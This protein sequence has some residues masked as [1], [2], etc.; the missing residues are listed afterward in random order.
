MGMLRLQCGF[1]SE[2]GVKY[3]LNIYDREYDDEVINFEIAAESVVVKHE[4]DPDDPFKRIVPSNLTFNMLLNCD[5]YTTEQ[6]EAIALFY[7]DVSESYEGR[8]FV[9]IR[10]LPFS[11]IDV[12]RGKII[13]DVGDVTMN[14]WRELRI[15][16]I[17][18]L[19]DLKNI[20]YR[21][22]EYSDLTAADAIKTYSFHDHFLAILKKNDVV[23]FFFEDL[24]T[25]LT[26][27]VMSTAFNWTSILSGIG[28]ITRQVR[29]RNHY[30]EQISSTY[31]KY[32]TCYNVLQDMLN[33]FNARI[34]FSTSVYQIE[35]L[36]YQNISPIYR[37][38]TRY[39]GTDNT[40]TR[41]K[42][43]TTIESSV[44]TKVLADPTIKLLPAFKAI[45]LKQTKEFMNYMNGMAIS[46]NGNNGP[47]NFGPVI[48]TGNKLLFQWKVEIFLGTAWSTI[49]W[50]PVTTIEWELSFKCRIGDNYLAVDPVSFPNGKMT[51]SPGVLY[52]VSIGQ[53]PTLQ[54]SVTEE[55]VTLQWSRVITSANST[56]FNNQVSVFRQFIKNIDLIIESFEI[57]DEGDLEIEFMDFVTRRNGS[58]VAGTPPGSIQITK[59][60]RIIVASGYNDLLEPPDDFISYQVNDIRNTLIYKTELKY[61]D[62]EKNELAQLFIGLDEATQEPSTEWECDILDEQL[63]IQQLMLLQMISMRK[64]PVKLINCVMY[65]K[66][67]LVVLYFDRRYIWGSL[68][69][70]PLRQEHNLT[71]DTYALTL[72]HPFTH[73]FENIN[74]ID[75]GEPFSFTYPI[76]SGIDSAQAISNQIQSYYQEW[77][78]PSDGDT[79]VTVDYDMNVILDDAPIERIRKQNSVFKNGV[80]QRYIDWESLS[81]PPDVGDLQEGEYTI[82]PD[83]DQIWFGYLFQNDKIE[84]S[85]IAI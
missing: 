64:L 55:T 30:F 49:A 63:P 10:Q 83:L 57:P 20:E 19:T 17:C 80:K 22:T 1:R 77:S 79:Y 34:F 4:G 78:V 11:E 36:A 26:G 12:F 35:Q 68:T 76:Q 54:W 3:E 23:K 40:G 37:Y 2:N 15:T 25:P 6:H 53:I 75:T 84:Y 18:G 81:F 5:L 42:L 38:Y 31:R 52:H 82:L 7:Y 14:Y 32:D 47:H 13:A 71:N 29:M 72:Y 74:R 58:V 69:W 50:T 16:A 65:Q 61:F 27:N 62:S 85:W 45:E 41:N 39:D 28:D 44:S 66:S 21:P 59:L 48:A 60:S 56:D 73:T 67:A 33:G 46:V 70:I 51:I 9:Q 24:D 8:F 43:S